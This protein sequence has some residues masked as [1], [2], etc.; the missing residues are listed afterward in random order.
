MTPL[1]RKRTPEISWHAGGETEAEKKKGMVMFFAV[2]KSGDSAIQ[3]E[4][5][6]GK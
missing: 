5:K 4:K 1:K 3:P 2:R 6:E